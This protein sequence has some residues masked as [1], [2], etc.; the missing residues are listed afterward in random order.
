MQWKMAYAHHEQVQ[1]KQYC[2]ISGLERSG[3]S[4]LP[5]SVPGCMEKALMKAGK[6]DDLYFGTNTLQAQRLEDVHLWYF[7]KI[8]IENK[9]Q[10]LRFKGID[11]FSDIYINGKLV[12]STDNMFLSYDVDADWIIGENEVVVHIKPTMLE[13]RN[14]TLP[15]VS[16]ALRY[17]YAA[18][19]VRKAAHMF[20]WDIMPRIVSAAQPSV[21]GA[22]GRR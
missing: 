9:N 15:A 7:T 21:A 20:G 17:N 3:F 13:A 16:Y 19:Y 11:T 2:T 22:L 10:Y 8:Q 1:Q 4:V 18:L 5:A 14:F 12:S 6:L